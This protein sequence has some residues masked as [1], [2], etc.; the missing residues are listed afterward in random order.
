MIQILIQILIRGGRHRR[1][2]TRQRLGPGLVPS[3]ETPR[4]ECL[5]DV[6]DER[7]RFDVVR[8]PGPHLRFLRHQHPDFPTSREVVKQVLDR[9]GGHVLREPRVT[10][11][12]HGS[13]RGV[14]VRIVGRDRELGK[15]HQVVVTEDEHLQ[16]DQFG[17][18]RYV[19]EP[20]LSEVQIGQSG[21]LGD[22]RRRHGERAVPQL[23][24]PQRV[25]LAQLGL[26]RRCGQRALLPAADDDELDQTVVAV[27]HPRPVESHALPR[28]R[29]PLPVPVPEAHVRP[30]RLKLRHALAP[31][32]QYANVHQVG[33]GVFVDVIIGRRRA[34]RGVEDARHGLPALLRDSQRDLRAVVV[35]LIRG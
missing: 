22:G 30:L 11:D 25:E 16:V 1:R 15:L 2:R 20:V 19:R 31:Q 13:Q 4:G 24:V 23:E 29:V 6:S 9:R 7:S 5:C 3:R 14:L 10:R 32:S 8:V 27:T 17:Y 34:H 28:R 12:F 33:V 35:L 18:I 21:E 26:Q